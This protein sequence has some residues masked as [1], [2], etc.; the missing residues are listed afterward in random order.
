MLIIAIFLASVMYLSTEMSTVLADTV[1][2]L[3][4]YNIDETNN[5]KMRVIKIKNKFPFPISIFNEESSMD[6]SFLSIVEP[7]EAIQVASVNGN[8][9]Y[10]SNVDGF[11]RISSIFIQLGTD[12][13]TFEPVDTTSTSKG[14]QPRIAEANNGNDELEYH[15][16]VEH[17][18]RPHPAVRSLNRHELA[19]G[20]M[21]AKFRSLSGKKI[22]LWYDD[23]GEGT[24]Q[25]HL[26]P[27]QETTTNTYVGHE[28]FATYGDNKDEEVCRFRITDDQTLYVINDDIHPAAQHIVDQTRRE[29]KFM[30]DYRNR[31]G[32][33]WRHYYGLDGPRKPPESFMWPAHSIGDVHQVTSTAG[34]W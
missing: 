28:F 22:N 33:Q 24:M 7:D 15:T 26:S 21:A 18:D 6:G 14:G 11:E 10:A 20:A 2:N 17:R 23:G 19:S 12:Q 3:K 25:A 32:I 5:A 31:T 29:E 27:G 4:I 13:Y 1:K 9:I 8:V 16:F 30:A 34:Y